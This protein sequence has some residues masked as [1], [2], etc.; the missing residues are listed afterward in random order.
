MDARAIDAEEGHDDSCGVYLP[1]EAVTVAA[2]K[3]II[4]LM[5]RFI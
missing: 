3:P 1:I 2:E 4:V 5:L